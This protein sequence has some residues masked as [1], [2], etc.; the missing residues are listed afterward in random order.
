MVILRGKNVGIQKSI[1][2]GRP[3]N[4]DPLKFGGDPHK[5]SRYQNGDPT[6]IQIKTGTQ[7]NTPQNGDPKRTKMRTPKIRDQNST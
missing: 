5:K 3:K 6:K 1:K 4:L 2:I 7:Q